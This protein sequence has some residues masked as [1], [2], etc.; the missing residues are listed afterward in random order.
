MSLDIDFKQV[1]ELGPALLEKLDVLRD[2]QPVYWSETQGAWL[3][4]GHAEV[5][6]GFRGDVPLTAGGRIQRVLNVVPESERHRIP[7][8]LNLVPKF[9]LNMDP[10]S[11]VRLR[12][13]MIRAFS[14]KVAEAQRPYVKELVAAT[15]ARAATGEPVEFVDEVGR[16]IAGRVILRLLNMPEDCFPRLGG[17]SRSLSGGISGGGATLEHVLAAE[18]AMVEMREIL[19]DEMARRRTAP[20]EDFISALMAA[21]IEGDRLTEDEIIATCVLTLIAG[22]DTTTNTMTLG[23]LSLSGEPEALAYVGAH[24]DA[25]VESAVEIL[26]HCGMSTAQVRSVREDFEWRGQSLKAGQQVYLM[27]AAANRDPSVYANP[28]ELDLQ[29]SNEPSMNFGPGLHHCIGHLLAKVQLSEFF[30]ALSR[31][32][33]RIEVLDRQLDWSPGL[34]FRGLHTLNVKLHPKV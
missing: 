9:I 30:P 22:H 25:A 24:P 8:L 32:V 28:G 2:A 3:V 13:L 6:Q 5:G 17:W 31:T 14:L 29:R 15:L 26:R 21:E 23:T 11:L 4:T 19:L 1:R 18:Q 7:H 34:S 27:V 10:P 33:G 12:Q 20:G 16:A